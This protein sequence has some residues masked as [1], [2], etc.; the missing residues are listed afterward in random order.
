MRYCRKIWWS[1]KGQKWRHNT[2]HTSY[3]LDKQGY[4]H[5]RACAGPSARTHAHTRTQICNP[6]CFSTAT[7]V[8]WRHLS[9]TLYI[10][11]LYFTFLNS[12]CCQRRGGG[13]WLPESLSSAGSWHLSPCSYVVLW[14]KEVAVQNEIRI[15][16]ATVFLIQIS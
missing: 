3:V 16:H 8:T 12:L 7:L 5:A 1:Q 13:Q 6:Y 14:V 10:H 15:F 2:A 4:M 11:R 9:V